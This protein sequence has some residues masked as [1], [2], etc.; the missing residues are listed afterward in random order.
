[1]QIPA[2]VRIGALPRVAVGPRTILAAWRHPGVGKIL[3]QM[4]PALLG[5]SV[6]QF[7]LL[8]N[9]QIASHRASAPSPGSSIADR[10]MEFPTALLGVA[11]VSC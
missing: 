6:A 9:T 8:I 10:L 4:A 1:V 2:L 5:V 3:S 7:S 11:S